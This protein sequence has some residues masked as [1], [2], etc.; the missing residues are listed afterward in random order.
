MYPYNRNPYD[1][2]PEFNDPL[3]PKMR[4]DQ[5]KV[6]LDRHEKELNDNFDGDWGEGNELLGF[7]TGQI[8]MINEIIKLNES[9]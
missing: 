1:I 2:T 8:E 4:R 5:I 9:E 6:N 3:E 7:M